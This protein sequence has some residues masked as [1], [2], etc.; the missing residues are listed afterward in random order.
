MPTLFK[1]GLAIQTQYRRVTDGQTDIA[2]WQRPC[3]AE[4][5]MGKR[6]KFSYHQHKM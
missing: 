2:Q 1:I 3:Y 6:D 5:R 4:H